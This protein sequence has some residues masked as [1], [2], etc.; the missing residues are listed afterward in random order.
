MGNVRIVWQLCPHV[1]KVPPRRIVGRRLSFLS[2]MADQV[3][4]LTK[5]RAFTMK[6]FP[7]ILHKIVIICAKS[8][9]P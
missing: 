3:R 5:F 7:E 6:L 4:R 1:F 8:F 9:P 2:N